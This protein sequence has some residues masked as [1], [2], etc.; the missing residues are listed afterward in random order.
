MQTQLGLG[1]NA[2]LRVDLNRLIYIQRRF[3]YIP[4]PGKTLV[5]RRGRRQVCLSFCLPCYYYFLYKNKYV[6]KYVQKQVIQK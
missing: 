1:R 2:L 3:R 5:S 6:R 4:S